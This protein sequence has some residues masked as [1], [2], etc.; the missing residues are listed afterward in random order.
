MT[1][2]DYTAQEQ[3]IREEILAHNTAYVQQKEAEKEQALLKNKD[4]KTSS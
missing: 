2:N 1:H 3:K 4:N